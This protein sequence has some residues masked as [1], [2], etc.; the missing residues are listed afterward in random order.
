MNIPIPIQNHP[1]LPQE[2]PLVASFHDDRNRLSYYYP[3]LCQI[4]EITVPQTRFVY[5]EFE[6]ETIP[7]MDC[8]DISSFMIEQQLETAFIRGDYSSGK[9]NGT[10]GSKITSQD[11]DDIESV[12][13]E[14]IRQLMKNKRRLGSILAVR[15]WVPHD[16]EV[17][18]II[19][20]GEI[21]SKGSEQDIP[22]EDY[23][24]SQA[25]AVAREF[26]NFSWSC[27]FIKHKQ[28]DKWY[29]ID[30]GLHGLYYDGDISDSYN[31][32]RW[33]AISE[34]PH[35]EQSLH[36]YREQMPSPRRLYRTR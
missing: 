13:L 32:N 21:T 10:D 35:R 7:T 34:H 33:T 29:C 3:Q 5:S 27:D 17:R 31:T 6:Y 8:R 23:P 1:E 20:D 11:R 36:Q 22:T 24:D 16:V 30:M 9:Y 18:Y 12:V 15:E 4:E 19:T 26:S 25:Q 2:I 14:L 28:T